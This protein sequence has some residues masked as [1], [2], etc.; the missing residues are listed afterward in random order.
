MQLFFSQILSYM[1]LII[2]ICA[3]C[4][5]L[6][7]ESGNPSKTGLLLSYA[8]MIDSDVREMVETFSKLE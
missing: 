2:N 7:T 8:F 6:F 1:S 4:F 5:C 3:I